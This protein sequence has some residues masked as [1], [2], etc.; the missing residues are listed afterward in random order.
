M[1]RPK[2]TMR[3]WVIRWHGNKP[4]LEQSNWVPGYTPGHCETEQEA[5][6]AEVVHLMDS[7]AAFRAKWLAINLLAEQIK[8]Q[9]V[10]DAF[11]S[12]IP[13]DPYETMTMP[14]GALDAE[15]VIA[16]GNEEAKHQHVEMTYDNGP[17]YPDKAGSAANSVRHGNYDEDPNGYD[18]HQDH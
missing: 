15:S 18:D 17:K 11:G 4:V 9:M 5:L 6:A 14:E 10:S 16:R 8:Y 2:D 7:I 1:V 13:G 12:L 3:S